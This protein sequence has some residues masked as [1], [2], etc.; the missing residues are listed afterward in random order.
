MKVAQAH[1]RD[2][3]VRALFMGLGSELVLPDMPGVSVGSPLSDNAASVIWDG[4]AGYGRHA[5]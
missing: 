3:P 5:G 4:R 2:H 1:L